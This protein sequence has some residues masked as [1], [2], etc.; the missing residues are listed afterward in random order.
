MR[1]IVVAGAALA[2]SSCL[3][4]TGLSALAQD[5]ETPDM[6][7]SAPELL[8]QGAPI[9]GANGVAV[10][11]EGRVL[12]ASVW[13]RG[14][15][16]LDPDTGEIVERI[17]PTIGDVDTGSP[18][19]VAVGPDGSICWTD[20]LGGYVNCLRT[21]GSLD[22]QLVAQGVNPIAFTDDGRLFV[23]LAF[24]GDDLFELDPALMAEPRLVME[25]EGDAPWP[26]QLNG[27]DFG[28][29][30]LL[31]APRPFSATGGEIGRI[32]VDA[33]VPEFETLVSGTPAFSVEFDS[34]G[35]LYATLA[36]TPEV[37]K[38]DI[39]TGRLSPIATLDPG[40][41]N[42]AFGPAGQ[43]YVSNSDDGGVHVIGTDGEVR[44][45]SAPGLVLPGGIS[46]VGGE[47]DGADHLYVADLW[48]LAEFDGQ[49]GE[50]RAVTRQLRTGGSITEP[51]TVAPEGQNVIVTS[52]MSNLVQVWDPA[53]GM[54]VASWPDFA[55]PTNAIRFG[56]DLIVAELGTGSV[57]RQTPE[58]E[59]EAIA[60]GLMVPSGLAATDE[61]LWVT[62]WASGTVWQVVTGGERSMTE[63]ATGLANPEGIAVEPDGSLLVVESGIGRL[64]RIMPS[65]EKVTVAD[66]LPLGAPAAPNT[67]PAWAF[68][69]V[70][71]GP[72]GTIYL[73]SDVESGVWRLTE[74]TPD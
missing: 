12:V 51:W 35:Q 56:D 20:I 43:L 64:T 71:V 74:V 53:A 3:A 45:L 11:G 9:H 21:D 2:A 10:D 23:A 27:F 69:G 48:S 59:R 70:A 17:G 30:G 61:D 38:V 67:P 66:G 5:A 8:V 22:Q 26:N 34:D 63:V 13:G 33:A 42:M 41:D 40:L 28:P 6:G 73:T 1:S 29:D 36:L 32:D 19:D 68:N 31:Y 47:A 24:F 58:G 62:D 25:G 16:V 65:G 52:W 4:L 14:I 55:G 39:E 15:S 18:D 37:S 72:S 57:T 60:D 54:E 49:T 46:A 50:E 7:V 44:Q